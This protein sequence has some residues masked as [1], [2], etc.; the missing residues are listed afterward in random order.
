MLYFIKAIAY[1]V[2]GDINFLDYSY[3]TSILAQ[4]GIIASDEVFHPQFSYYY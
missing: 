4:N 1:K 3:A 2:N